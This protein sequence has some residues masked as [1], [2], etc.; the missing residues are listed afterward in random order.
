[1][2]EQA[3]ESVQR[4]TAASRA[5]G[6]PAA[7]DSQRFIVERS[8]PE[9]ERVSRPQ[10]EDTGRPPALRTGRPQAERARGPLAAW[11]GAQQAVKIS[12]RQTTRSGTQQAAHAGAQST[13]QQTERTGVQQ[14]TGAGAQQVP[15]IGAQQT[16]RAGT[17]TGTWQ[18]PRADAQGRTR[19][20]SQRG[21]SGWHIA[22]PGA[23]RVQVTARGAML[24]MFALCLAG[25]LAAASLHLEVLVGV[26]YCAA[27]V[28]APAYAA[29]RA[30]LEV[31]TAPPVAFLLAVVIVQALTAQ[32][33]SS[34]AS[35]LSVLEGT[36]LTLA[37]TAPWLFAGTAL[38]VLIA[39][40]RGLPQCIR[41]LRANLRGDTGPDGTGARQPG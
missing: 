27:C 41:D 12:P 39:M 33:D 4:T 29:R 16:A 37:A 10:A 3:A 25:S 38:C 34:H 28:L 40:R 22:T 7:R 5:P 36:L 18:T 24:G 8:R 11:V 32:G 14:T 9:A 6:G 13:A 30:M 26:G 17:R 31:V 15:P 20:G 2:P 19:L 35:M 23:T 1:M 21:M